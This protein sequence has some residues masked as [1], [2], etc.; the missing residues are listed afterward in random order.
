[1]IRYV[2]DA[3]C[4]GPLVIPDEAENLIPVVTGAL[5]DESCVV[6]QHWRFEVGNLAPMAVR[7]KRVDLPT[8]RANLHDL[9]Q[10]QVEIDAVSSELAWTRTILLAEH[11]GLTVYDAAYLELAQRHGL[12]LLSSD[13]RLLCAAAGEGVVTNTTP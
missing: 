13:G 8:V 7:R 5:A 12:T 9:S 6:P 4:V 11:H 1:M 2:L 10:F 3:S